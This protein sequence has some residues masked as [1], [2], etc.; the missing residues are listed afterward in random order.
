MRCC[1]VV[2]AYAGFQASNCQDDERYEAALAAFRTCA[3]AL[4]ICVGAEHEAFAQVAEELRFATSRSE[5][6]A[7]TP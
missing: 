2:D 5:K 3:A 6:T 7:D 4:R 1:C